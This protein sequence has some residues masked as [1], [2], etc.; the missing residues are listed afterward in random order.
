MG[1]ITSNCCRSDPE[2]EEIEGT[3]GEY[4]WERDFLERKCINSGYVSNATIVSF[5]S[6]TVRA[7]VPK[8]FTPDR[9]GVHDIISAL[10]GDT[11]GLEKRNISLG[12]QSPVCVPG[13]LDDGKAIYSSDGKEGGCVV[14]KT[15]HCVLVVFYSK[16]AETAVNF[17]FQLAR[18]ME[19]NGR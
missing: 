10:K 11:S 1:C 17:A 19:E 3:S 14:Y 18:Y 16:N 9:I 8:D 2:Y 4:A 7:S 6:G 15:K 5:H 13:K 12:G